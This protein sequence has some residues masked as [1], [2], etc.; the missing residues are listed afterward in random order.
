MACAMW[1]FFVG[2][3]FASF[4]LP[5]VN[6]LLQGAEFFLIQLIR[7]SKLSAQCPISEIT[8]NAPTAL[9]ISIYSAL[10]AGSFSVNAPTGCILTRG[11]YLRSSR[12]FGSM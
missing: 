5:F 4:H 12:I 8:L 6:I 2:L 3:I 9:Q 1:L 7:I 10:L 11:A